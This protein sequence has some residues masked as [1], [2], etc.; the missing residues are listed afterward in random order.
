ME[1][2]TDELRAFAGIWLANFQ[3]N[4][5]EAANSLKTFNTILTENPDVLPF[6][7]KE[8]NQKVMGKMVGFIQNSKTAKPLT[9]INK[10]SQ[11][12]KELEM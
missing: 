2:F 5:P 6:L 9:M 10:L 4:E 12:A 3:G 7:S 8:K 11:M 1:Q